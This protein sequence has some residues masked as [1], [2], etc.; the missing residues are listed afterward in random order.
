MEEFTAKLEYWYTKQISE[1]QFVICGRIFGDSKQRFR[2]GET[3]YTSS[4]K[5]IPLKEGDIVT[6]RNSTYLLGSEAKGEVNV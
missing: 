3:I 1:E 2:N 6:T 5:I 4:I